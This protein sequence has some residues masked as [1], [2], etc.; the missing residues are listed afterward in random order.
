MRSIFLVLCAAAAVFVL[1]AEKAS[2]NNYREILSV[3]CEYSEAAD[4]FHRS[5]GR[6]RRATDYSERLAQRLACAAGDLHTAIRRGED[7]RR[8]AVLY[9]EVY[10]LHDRLSELLGSRCSR[11]DPTVL[12]FWH[13][14]DAAFDRL[15]CAIEGCHSVCP[16]I[17][18]RRQV[19]ARPPV[20][21]GAPLTIQPGFSIPSPFGQDPFG[22]DSFGRGNIGGG[23]F[24]NG[25][26]GHSHFERGNVDQGRFDSGRRENFGRDW[27]Q[28]DI[29]RPD[30]GQRELNQRNRGQR[31]RDFDRD[32]FDRSQWDSQSSSQSNS[33]WDSRGRSDGLSRGQSPSDM[34]AAAVQSILSRLFN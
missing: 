4:L 6:C 1:P 21:I 16:L 30:W 20:I 26:F 14:L 25:H 33:Q 24:G 32:R 28:R 34:R 11:P 13:P 12:A 18:H 15:V 29:G 9:D 7:P 27:G 3:S 2:A 8:V 22:R 23:P 17:T 19:V 31:D 10:L 5:L